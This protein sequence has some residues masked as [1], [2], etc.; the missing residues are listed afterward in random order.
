M[1]AESLGVHVDRNGE[2]LCPFHG[3]TN[4]SLHIYADPARGWACFGC[5][6]GGSVLDFAMQWYGITF[7]QAVVRLDA[8][9]GLGLP[10]GRKPT[11]QEQRMARL[12]REKRRQA[13]AARRAALEAA[14][15]A[16]REAHDR[17]CSLLSLID[18][19]RPRRL[20]NEISGL[21]AAALKLLPVIRDEFER[22]QDAL[23]QLRKEADG[24]GTNTAAA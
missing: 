1:L 8:D 9:F 15:A 12:E 17:Y 22:A 7:R 21:Y 18:G 5:H 23:E 16:F 3:D 19:T 11:P 2:A 24:L 4:K 13:Q 20:E 6:K 14:E 10:L